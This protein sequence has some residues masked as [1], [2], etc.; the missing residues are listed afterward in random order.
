MVITIFVRHAATCKYAGDEFCKRCNCR[1][2]FRWTQNGTQYRRKAGTRT[3]AEAEDLKRKLED[4]LAGRVPVETH[5]GLPLAQAIETGP[6]HRHRASRRCGS[7]ISS[8]RSWAEMLGLEMRQVNQRKR[9]GRPVKSQLVK[10]LDYTGAADKAVNLAGC[11][12]PHHQ[13]PGRVVSMS[14]ACG[15]NEACSART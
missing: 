2:H 14:D 8:G 6:Y 12:S 13:L 1:K 4:Q 11:K 5:E 9:L 7:A 10:N 15:G 3:W